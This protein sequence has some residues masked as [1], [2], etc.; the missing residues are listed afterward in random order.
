MEGIILPLASEPGGDLWPLG[1]C[2]G[3]TVAVARLEQD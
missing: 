1:V 2:W 3:V